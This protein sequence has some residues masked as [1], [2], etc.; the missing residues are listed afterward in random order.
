[1][2]A[3]LTFEPVLVDPGDVV[4]FDSFVPHRSGLNTTDQPR[5][6][7]YITFNRLSEGDF[8]ADYYALKLACW[9]KGEGGSISV[10][11][12]FMGT[13]VKAT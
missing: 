5:R 13:V 7:A 9:E 1:M 10:N 4:L 8:H 12:D 6:S 3:S 11:D 2:E